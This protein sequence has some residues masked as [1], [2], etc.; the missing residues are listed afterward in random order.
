MFGRYPASTPQRIALGLGLVSSICEQNY[1]GWE[2]FHLV[3]AQV[4]AQVVP[5]GVVGQVGVLVQNRQ[6]PTVFVC[7]RFPA[8]SGVSDDLVMVSYI[9]STFVRL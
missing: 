3:V 7:V 6:N 9:P 1:L 8:S 2:G 5:L 4:V